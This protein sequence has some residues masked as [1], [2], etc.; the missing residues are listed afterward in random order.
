MGPP[1][2]AGGVLGASFNDV[3]TCSCD[4]FIAE[5]GRRASTMG[6][7]NLKLRFWPHG[8]VLIVTI[9]EQIYLCAARD[10]FQI[11]I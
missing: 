5:A 10:L 6:P 3:M 2:A 9:D 8:S 4:E 7:L 1:G 11:G